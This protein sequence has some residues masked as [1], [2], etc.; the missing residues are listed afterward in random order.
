MTLPYRL[1]GRVALVTGSSRGI[2]RSIAEAFSA[3]GASVV[4]TSRKPDACDAVVESITEVGGAAVAFPGNAGNGEDCARIVDQT[5][6]RFGRL[7]ILVN[8][9]ATNPA[10]GL[11]LDLDE[12]LLDKVWSVNVK[13]PWC[14]ARHAVRRWMGSHGGAIINIASTSGMKSEA[15]IGAYAATKAAII[16][17]TATWARELGAQGIRVNAISPGLVRT[18]FARALLEDE[19]LT[20]RIMSLSSLG[21]PG[22]PDEIAGLAVFLASDAASYLTGANIVI[23]GGTL[24]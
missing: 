1:D 24:S 3:Q 6:E 21:R 2:G 4:I 16:S 12:A 22:E 20:E 9:A 19:E 10:Y 13:G 8:N 11:M 15:M 5:I 17:M 7:D 18:D 14:F 23:D